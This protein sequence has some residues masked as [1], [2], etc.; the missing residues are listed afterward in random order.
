MSSAMQ[1]KTKG[2]ATCEKKQKGCRK[3]ICKQQPGE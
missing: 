3:N 2:K 1:P